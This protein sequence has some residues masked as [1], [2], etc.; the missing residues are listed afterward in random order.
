M[1]LVVRYVP[2][3]HAAAHRNEKQH[4]GPTGP[5]QTITENEAHGCGEIR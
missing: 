1:Y 5:G 4:V 2:M 3:K